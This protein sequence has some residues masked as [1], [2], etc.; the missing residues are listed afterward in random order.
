M[1]S[2]SDLRG[3]VVIVILLMASAAFGADH[4]PVPE[5]AVCA[6]CAVSEGST[7]LEKVVE[8]R[9]HEGNCYYFCNAGC[10][11]AFDADPTPYL[12]PALPRPAPDV[13]FATPTGETVTL[14]SYRGKVV[15]VDFWATWCS[16]CI[17]ALPEIAALHTEKAASGFTA[18]GVCIDEDHAK[19]DKFL[20]KR[21]L[22]HPILFDDPAAPTWQTF[23][24]RA[25]PAAFLVD[26]EGR[27][28]A[29]WT[30]R[31]DIAAVRAAVS[32]ALAEK[33]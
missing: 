25:I 30:G 23:G 1:R 9:D 33:P 8:H 12:P 29:Q 3:V 31:V 5:K 22:A 21:T 16:P 4:P 27:I 15:L 10:A 19:R 32:A 14:Q 20:K 2:V 26:R 17:K 13:S 24:V 6:V 7:A 28:V 11:K 18:L